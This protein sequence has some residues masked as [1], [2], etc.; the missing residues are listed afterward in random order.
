M[1]KLLLFVAALSALAWLAADASAYTYADYGYSPYVSGGSYAYGYGYP[2]SGFGYYGLLRGDVESYNSS[3]LDYYNRPERYNPYVSDFTGFGMPYNW[4]TAQ[5]LGYRPYT[6]NRYLT[7]Y[8][9]GYGGGYG[10]GYNP[11]LVGGY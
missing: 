6:D 9:G 7:N 3:A 11:Y 5:G 8:G 4:K 2:Q 1:K 10:S